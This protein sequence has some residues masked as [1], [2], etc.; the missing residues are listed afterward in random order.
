MIMV[1]Q[2]EQEKNVNQNLLITNVEKDL[3]PLVG[4]ISCVCLEGRTG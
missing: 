2:I 4:T 3:I 1:E